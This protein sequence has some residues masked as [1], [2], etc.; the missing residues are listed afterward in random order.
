M[1]SPK[2]LPPNISKLKR[3]ERPK[4]VTIAA[5]FVCADGIIICA[6]TQETISGYTKSSAHKLK[7]WRDGGLNIVVTGAGDT[8]LIE[9]VSQLLIEALRGDYTEQSCWFPK[10]L[11]QIIQDTFLTFF[12]TSLLPYPRDERPGVDLLIGVA[13]HNERVAHESLFKASGTTVRE[14]D[15]GEGSLGA[16][17]VGMGVI[18]GNSLIERLYSP[19]LHLDELLIIAAYIIFQA[20]QWID[21]C[22]GDTDLII[23]GKNICRGVSRTDLAQLENYFAEFDKWTHDLV[24]PFSN[25]NVSDA[26]FLSELHRRQNQILQFRQDLL[27]A[28]LGVFGIMREL[29]IQRSGGLAT[30]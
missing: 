16:E 21:G 12:K 22:G 6:D 29:K 3:L 5:G 26:D 23:L 13:L 30:S 14:I 15:P 24:Q 28:N 9:T 8:E 19:F 18:L 27:K 4:R 25:V 20:K 2:P 1:I 11:C 10:K 7:V 17:C